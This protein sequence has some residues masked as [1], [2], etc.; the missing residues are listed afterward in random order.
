MRITSSANQSFANR[1][2][3]TS[4]VAASY[5]SNQQRVP[6]KNQEEAGGGGGAGDD[7][8]SSSEMWRR[9]HP[10]IQSNLS[11]AH[12]LL[13]KGGGFRQPT[14]P[15][16]P[17]ALLAPQERPLLV[18]PL[19]YTR[20]RLKAARPR[21]LSGHSLASAR[22]LKTSRSAVTVHDPA[23]A[24]PRAS[25]PP[26]DDQTSSRPSLPVFP[27]R[28]RPRGS[29]SGTASPTF[30]IQSTFPVQMQAQPRPSTPLARR[31]SES[32][33]QG[34]RELLGF[35]SNNGLA[36]E[37]SAADLRVC[38][39]S[40]RAHP[41]LQERHSNL[42]VAPSSHGLGRHQVDASTQRAPGKEN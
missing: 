25:V 4:G 11:R 2:G 13:S 37:A 15:S 32:K 29:E 34:L 18:P 21:P 6:Y 17:F 36:R 41:P 20:A 39:F 19:K 42:L 38:A 24:T 5:F 33:F 22:A 9:A 30:V 14:E 7:S 26:L 40:T 23:V 27:G 3:E 28:G 35:N 10:P 1:T 16:N 12:S 8:C 31:P